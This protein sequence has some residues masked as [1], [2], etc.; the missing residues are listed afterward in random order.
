MA[1]T[2][3]RVVAPHFVA[4]F[5]IKADRVIACA[6]I[7]RRALMGKTADQIRAVCKAKGWRASVVLR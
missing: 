5:V 3:V 6:P 4:G 7:L 1:E 2:L